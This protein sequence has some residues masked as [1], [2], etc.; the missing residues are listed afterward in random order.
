MRS[1]WVTTL[2]SSLLSLLL[3]AVAIVLL[4]V[5]FSISP[6]VPVLPGKNINIVN[7]VTID[8]KQ[9]ESELQKLKQAEEDKKAA[10][11]K[12]LE[13]L[14][15]KAAAEKKKAEDARKKRIEEENKLIAAKKKKELEQQKRELEQKKLDKV[16]KEKEELEKQKL[17]EQE[18][19]AVARAKRE[20]EE[21][22]KAAEEEKKRKAAEEAEKKRLA[23]EEKRLQDEIA[24]EEAE[25]QRQADGRLIAKVAADISEK[26]SN[27]FNKS[28]LSEGLNCVLRVKLL[29]GGEVID[30]A[31]NKTSGNDIFDRRAVVAVQKASPLPVPDDIAI[32]ERLDLRDIT[33]TFAP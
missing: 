33:F 2:N 15:K 20:E 5:S 10:E 6:R 22:I 8:N 14:E 7:A 30:V 9:I 11:K 25:Q 4:V 29:P 27:Y 12:R 13:E 19:E 23:E 18:K 17:I 26:V 28:G 31:V 21:K 32:F 3:H 1:G 16:K 24:A